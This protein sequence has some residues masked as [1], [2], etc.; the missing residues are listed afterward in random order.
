MLRCLNFISDIAWCQPS[1][2]LQ[3]LLCVRV[4]LCVPGS[5]PWPLCSAVFIFKDHTQPKLMDHFLLKNLPSHIC[6][7]SHPW[8]ILFFG[9][10]TSILC[11][12]LLFPY[13]LIVSF[14]GIFFFCCFWLWLFWRTHSTLGLL[15]F[16]E[17]TVLKIPTFCRFCLKI[18]GFQVTDCFFLIIFCSLYKDAIGRNML[19]ELQIDSL[20]ARN[21]KGVKLKCLIILF[22]I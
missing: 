2:F 22:Q 5:S 11:A 21:I 12:L 20:Q 3:A 13:L 8:F 18:S 6:L 4:T 19:F 10:L 9:F 14:V 1:S 7:H 16:W 15:L 17:S